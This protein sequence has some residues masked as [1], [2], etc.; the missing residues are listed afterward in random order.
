MEVFTMKHKICSLTAIGILGILIQGCSSNP[1]KVQKVETDLN[2]KEEVTKN[3]TLGIKKDNT[4][5]VQEKTD[6]RERLRDLQNEVFQLEDK[7]YGMRKFDSLGL[8][9][10]LRNCQKKLASKQ[11]G[12][13]GVMVWT[14]PLDRVSD[15]EKDYKYGSDEKSNLVSVSEEYVKD[16][17]ERFQNYKAILQKREDEF[18]DKIEHCQTELAEKKIDTQQS[19]KVLITE[20]SKALSEK[21]SLNT[22][23]CD[24]VKKGASLKEL[25]L[26]AFAERWLNMNDLSVNQTLTTAKIRD[27]KSK[28]KENGFLFMGWKLAYDKPAL[29]LGDVLSGNE[30][31][32]LQAWTYPSKKD[33]PNAGKCLS[34]SDGVWND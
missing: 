10:D 21:P 31:A 3:Q 27:Q 2:N 29:T 28:E 30:D 7:V 16:R 8:Y 15:K 11:Y 22:Y 4:L 26:S 12:G 19:S 1:Y 34:N 6:L 32:Q 25:L 18:K 17:L 14:E 13:P 24:Y 5:V 23:M 9:G 33:V 20:G